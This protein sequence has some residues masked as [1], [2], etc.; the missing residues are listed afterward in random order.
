MGPDPNFLIPP[1]LIQALD[2]S[3]HAVVMTGSGTSAESGIPTFRNAQTGLWAKYRPEDLATPEAFERDPQ[4]VLEWYAWRRELVGAAEP[5]PG[6]IAIAE[7]N[8]LLPHLTLI[9]QN[10]DGLHQRAGS[11]SVIE[12][13][14]NLMRSRCTAG[15]PADEID[16]I[17]NTGETPP[18]CRQCGAMLRPDVVWFGEAIPAVALATALEAVEDC[19]ILFAIGTSAVVQPA[20]GLAMQAKQHGALLVEVNPEPTPL[21]RDVDF[22]LTGSSGRIMPELVNALRSRQDHA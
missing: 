4:L 15:H 19:D 14:G 22:V 18:R 11:P 21:T 3:R 1:D 8:D 7:L 13:H 12:F 10:V 20:A 6:H 17:D 9:T 2:R 16:K 5:N